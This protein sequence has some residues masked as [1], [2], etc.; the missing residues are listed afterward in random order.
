MRTM[1]RNDG[2]EDENGD[3]ARREAAR[4]SKKKARPS[5]A[6]SR[7]RECATHDCL[8]IHSFIRRLDSAVRRHPSPRATRGIERLLFTRT[9][10]YTRNA[11]TRASVVHRGYPAWIR[12][13]LS[14]YL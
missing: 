12:R 4:S 6:H 10:A 3:D 13:E 2:D 9:H 8:K 7:F 5:K 14:V 11:G 1:R